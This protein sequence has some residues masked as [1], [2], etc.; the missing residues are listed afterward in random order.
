MRTLSSAFPGPALRPISQ[1][2][3]YHHKNVP[4]VYGSI[5]GLEVDT[6]LLSINTIL[7]M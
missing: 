5:Q 1:M 4:R 2:I 7:S 6:K 3:A